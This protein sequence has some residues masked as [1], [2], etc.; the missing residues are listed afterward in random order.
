MLGRQLRD[1][2]HELL[3]QPDMDMK[4]RVQVNIISIILPFVKIKSEATVCV[5]VLSEENY[6]IMALV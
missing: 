1:I 2:Y 6:N 5:P 4:M 3:T